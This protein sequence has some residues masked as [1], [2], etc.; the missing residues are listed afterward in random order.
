MIRFSI[1]HMTNTLLRGNDSADLLSQILGLQALIESNVSRGKRLA[2]QTRAPTK[3]GGRRHRDFILTHGEKEFMSETSIFIL[4]APT[5][6][7]AGPVLA[8]LAGAHGRPPNVWLGAAKL[9]S[10]VKVRHASTQRLPFAQRRQ[11]PG[12]NRPAIRRLIPAHFH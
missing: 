3:D 7:S 11:P 6:I 8:G 10:A 1:L 9:D 5:H 12:R 2:V 4:G